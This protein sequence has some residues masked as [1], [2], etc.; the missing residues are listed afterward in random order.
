MLNLVGLICYGIA[1]WRALIFSRAAASV[2]LAGG[3]LSVVAFLV[4][5]SSPNLPAWVSDLPGQIFVAAL[6]W[7]GFQLATEDRVSRS[8]ANYAV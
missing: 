7:L 5:S 3:L 1:T 2:L 8:P 6:A 4:G